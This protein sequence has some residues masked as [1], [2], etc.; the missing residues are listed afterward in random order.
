MQIA[1]ALEALDD[2]HNLFPENDYQ[3]I[4]E[5]IKMKK[6]KDR[7]RARDGQAG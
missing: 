6:T 7:K 1:L 2:F 5:M 4:D 3:S